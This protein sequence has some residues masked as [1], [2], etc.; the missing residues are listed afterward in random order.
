MKKIA[1]LISFIFSP[2]L[3]PTYGVWV[4]MN[5]T[6]LSELPARVLW[7]V[8]GVTFLITCILPLMAI[9]GM[10]RLGSVSDPGL[11]ERTERTAPFT[12]TAVSYILCAVYL[13]KANAP[14]WL[15]LFMVGATFATVVSLIVNRWW[16]ISAHMA[17][18][19]GLFGL[20]VRIALSDFATAD[21]LWWVA[22]VAVCCGLVGT[23]RIGLERHTPWQVAAGWANG[24]VCV[25]LASLI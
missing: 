24:F 6:V 23:A 15:V 16:K 17:A 3:V 10:W 9:A 1:S 19:G 25:L 2:L 5:T 12:V 11:N 4:A 22:G 14:S 21:M 13:S 18:M 7:G 8:P 20:T